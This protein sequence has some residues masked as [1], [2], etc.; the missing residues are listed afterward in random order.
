MN[1]Y[2]LT[3]V[4]ENP[5]NVEL[6]KKMITSLKGKVNDEKHWGKLEFAYPIDKLTAADYFT[7]QVQMDTKSLAE[8]KQKLNFDNDII[9]FLLLKTD[10]K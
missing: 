9:R 1:S 2:E 8:F 3:F 4:V 6:V 5:K 7:W 10:S